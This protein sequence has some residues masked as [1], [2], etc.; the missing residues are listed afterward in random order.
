MQKGFRYK[1]PQLNCGVFGKT[2][3]VPGR[4]DGVLI[5]HS[6]RVNHNGVYVVSEI[7]FL[8]LSL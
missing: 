4:R 5:K 1:T 3:S 8:F 6:N 7:G 2:C